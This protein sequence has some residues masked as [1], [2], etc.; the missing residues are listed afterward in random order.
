MARPGFAANR[1]KRPGVGY[2][3]PWPPDIS[4]PLTAFGWYAAAWAED[5]LW[6][7]PDDGGAVSSWRNGGTL[8]TAFEQS[9]GAAQPTFRS[10]VA[11]LNN[12][13][14]VDFDGTD[15][16][17][18]VLSGVSVAV[19]HSLVVIGTSDAVPSATKSF[20]GTT[21]TGGDRLGIAATNNFVSRLGGT[22][23]TSTGGSG[24]TVSANTPYLVSA[25]NNGSV[26]ASTIFVN[27]TNYTSA[28]GGATLTT[29]DG[30]VLGA[31]RSAVST[32]SNYLDGQ[33][34]FAGFYLGDIHAHPN[35]PAFKRWV[36]S[37]YAF[38]VA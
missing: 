10:A 16:Y 34:A 29:V 25:Y 17:L 18:G 9:T 3:G 35:W 22:Q 6:T 15:D 20:I 26:P 1:G 5:P 31:S 38:T 13:P 27:G 11:A 7:P 24:I 32:F 2:Q 23:V 28:S 30:V 12:R 33:I 4:N 37:R 36:A 14:A 8:G 19:A 21:S